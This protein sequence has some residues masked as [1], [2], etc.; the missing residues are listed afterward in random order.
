M[1]MARAVEGFVLWLVKLS[2]VRSINVNTL[3]CC[4]TIKKLVQV[5][6]MEKSGQDY[7]QLL[8]SA[9]LFNASKML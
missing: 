5:L 8:L 7:K 1:C 9:G 4:I 2:Q 3:I 6:K